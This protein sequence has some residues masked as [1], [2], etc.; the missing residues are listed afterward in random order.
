[1]FIYDFIIY[2]RKKDWVGSGV[3]GCVGSVEGVIGLFGYVGSTSNFM[4]FCRR[5]FMARTLLF[6]RVLWFLLIRRCWR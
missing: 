4:C 6:S 3:L 2:S 1:M 5:R